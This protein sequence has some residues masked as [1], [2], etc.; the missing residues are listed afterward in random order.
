[1]KSYFDILPTLIRSF[2]GSVS[3]EAIEHIVTDPRSG[4]SY[5]CA[6]KCIAEIDAT[7]EIFNAALHSRESVPMDRASGQDFATN[8]PAKFVL[9]EANLKNFANVKFQALV[10]LAKKDDSLLYNEFVEVDNARDRVAADV[11]S[12]YEHDFNS[13]LVALQTTEGVDKSIVDS[14]IQTKIHV[15]TIN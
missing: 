3:R 13:F 15:A 11:V 5:E 9:E 10:D 2:P 12:K 7:N 14:L 8:G 1:M 4:M 6:A